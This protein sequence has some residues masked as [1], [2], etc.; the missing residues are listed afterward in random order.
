MRPLENTQDLVTIRKTLPVRVGT[1]HV[2]DQHTILEQ[3]RQMG[4]KGLTTYLTYQQTKTVLADEA[5]Q[6]LSILD[7]KVLWQVHIELL[8]RKRKRGRVCGPCF[9][10]VW[11]RLVLALDQQFFNFCNCLRRV[12][13]FWTS[14]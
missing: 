13:T 10:P 9:D 8:K 7:G 14:L 4:R 11:N 3:E 2:R 12:E 1:R 6:C 5:I